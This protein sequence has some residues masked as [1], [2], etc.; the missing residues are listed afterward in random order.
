[1][2][3]E[4]YFLKLIETIDELKEE[5][6]NGKPI[7]VEGKK[8]IESLKKLGIDGN[9][10]T[11]SH[12]PFFEIADELVKNGVKEVILLT[13]FDRAGKHY[14]KEIIEELESNGIK[15]NTNIRRDIL[16]YS[17][18]DLKDIESLYSYIIRKCR[19]YQFSG[20]CMEFIMSEDGK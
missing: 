7:L 10:I 16:I 11:V 6:K 20:K 2:K 5:S 3:R 17:H 12:T 9:F 19:E 4:E 1:M 14:A 13:D 8:D 15:V 18:G